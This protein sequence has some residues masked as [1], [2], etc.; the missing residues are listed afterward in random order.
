MSVFEQWMY[1]RMVDDSPEAV[2]VADADGMIRFWNTAAMEVFGHTESEALGQT[3]DLIVP[4]AQRSRHWAGYHQV[5]RTGETRYGRDLLAVPAMRKDGVR[6]S[7][8]FH[9]VLLRD[10]AGALV[11]VA[12]FLRDVT[13]RWQRERALANRVRELESELAQ[14]RQ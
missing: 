4:E 11:G 9:V 1:Q 12:A 8:E 5:M 2:I 13:A 14:H 3:L 7:V 10:S 6:I